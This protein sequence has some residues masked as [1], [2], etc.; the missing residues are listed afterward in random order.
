MEPI[1]MIEKVCERVNVTFEEAREALEK[2]N[3][4]VEETL[5]YFEEQGK[6]V[7]PEKEEKAEKPEIIEIKEYKETVIEEEDK[8][9]T[10]RDL[11]HKAIDYLRFNSIRVEKD[12]T[13]IVRIRLFLFVILMCVAG[14][15]V[16]PVMIVGLFLNFRYSIVGKNSFKTVN[17]M[18][19]SV[20]RAAQAAKDEFTKA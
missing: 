6:E 18:M 9:T 11:I 8:G 17:K 1:E 2:N 12:G 14:H 7:K 20:S 15:V 13:E 19:D 16:L 5:K 3:W 10:I 4:N